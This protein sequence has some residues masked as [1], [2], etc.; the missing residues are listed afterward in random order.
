M[1]FEKIV[2]EDTGPLEA[3]RLSEFLGRAENVNAVDEERA[4]CVWHT[5]V[6][7][8]EVETEVEYATLRRKLLVGENEFPHHISKPSMVTNGSEQEQHPPET[9]V[10]YEGHT[11]EYVT[12]Q[13][14]QINPQNMSLI[15][16][17]IQS[18]TSDAEDLVNR[19]D[20]NFSL[21]A[22]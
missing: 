22:E 12:T 17:E 5:I 8:H 10:M 15:T 11:V 6:K 21:S 14:S 2:D 18:I 4:G 20:T 1:F 16:N 19:I 7:Y 13:T 9:P 3:L